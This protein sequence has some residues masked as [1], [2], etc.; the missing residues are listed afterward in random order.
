MGA[1]SSCGADAGDAPPPPAPDQ[2]EGD[3]IEQ[4]L[5]R[6]RARMA[7]LRLRLPAAEIARYTPHCTRVS[8]QRGGG[9]AT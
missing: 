7:R 8:C 9:Y 2:E 3:S 6:D 5:A 1:C 4:L